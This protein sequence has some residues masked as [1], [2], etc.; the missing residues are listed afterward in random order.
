MTRPDPAFLADIRARTARHAGDRTAELTLARAEY[1]HG[2]VAVGDA[3]LERWLA[4]EPQDVKLLRLTG[5]GHLVAGER[6]PAR[7]LERFRAARTPLSRAY[8]LDDRD[9]RILYAF[10]ISRMVEPNFPTENDVAALMEARAMAPAVQTT[11]IM[12][13]AALLRRG[14]RERAQ[15]VLAPILNNP[16]GGPMP[17]QARALLEGKTLAEAAADGASAEAEPPIGPEPGQSS[18]PT[19]H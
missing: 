17:A 13:G 11:S 10:A 1:V 5:L 15:K 14:D 19:V 4:A 3:I 16:H 9:Y 2:D 12:A 6:D 7:R 18:E 8:R